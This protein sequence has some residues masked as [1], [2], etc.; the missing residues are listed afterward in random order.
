VT[1]VF[2]APRADRYDVVVAGSGAAALMAAA[3]AAG[4]GHSVLVAERSGLLGGTSSISAGTVWVPCHPYR[5]DADAADDPAEALRYLTAVAGDRGRPAV[6][7]ALVEHGAP[8]LEFAKDACGLVFDAVPDYPDYRPGLPGSADGRSLQPR[9]F[10]VSALGALGDALRRDPVPPYTMAEFKAWGSWNAFPWDELRTRAEAGWVARGGA[11]VAPLLAACAAR[12]VHLATNFRVDGLLTERGR[13]SGVTVVS[14]DPRA[15]D[16]PSARGGAGTG[17]IIAAA[18][19]VILACGGFEWNE[20]MLATHL[21]GRLRGRCSPPSNTGDGH[22][23]AAAAGAALTDLDQA[24][25]APMADL[26]GDTRDGRPVGRLIRT[27]RQG[28]GTIVVDATGRRF[29][30]ES[31]DYNSFIRAW[32]ASRGHDPDGRDSVQGGDG[33]S[34]MYVVFDHRFLDRFGFITH[35]SGQPVPG[36]LTCRSSIRELAEALPVDPERLAVTVARFNAGAVLGAD[37]DFDRGADRYDRYGGDAANPWPNSCLAPLDQPPFY[38]MPLQAGAFGTS[39]GVVTDERARALDASG[40]VIAGLFAVGNVSAHPVCAG[41]PGAGGTLG[42]ALTMGYLAGLSV[43]AGSDSS[44]EPVP[45]ARSRDDRD[46]ARQG[47]RGQGAAR[48]ARRHRVDH[49]E[50]PGSRQRAGT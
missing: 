14:E 34:A 11:L 42:P 43:G 19:G 37:P 1:A 49:P 22:R 44:Q 9:L 39:G 12:G 27:E 31:Q 29:A 35:R 18:A 33:S 41:Y 47:D 46:E 36:W 8:M 20:E 2:G 3:V 26:P 7:G 25:W 24:W 28:P 10:N 38:G 40:E 5:S 21:G 4:R 32:F 50:P 6:L 15:S 13:V 17:R 23:I 30:D 45:M 16:G 48:G